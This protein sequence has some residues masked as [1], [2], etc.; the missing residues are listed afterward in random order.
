MIDEDVFARLAS[1]L[2]YVHGD[3]T[4][5]ATYAEVAK[6]VGDAT[7]P[8]FYLEVPP[9]LFG[10]VVGGLVERGSHRECAC[11]RRE[12]VRARPRFRTR[13]ERRACTP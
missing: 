8:V 7:S 9:S 3:F 12:A 2:S 13:A 1:R 4:D 6:A 11:R 10:T 5:A